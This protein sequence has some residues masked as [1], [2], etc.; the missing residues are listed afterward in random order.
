MRQLCFLF[1]LL[2]LISSSLIAQITWTGAGDGASWDD[3]ANW[4]NLT[5]PTIGDDVI[6]PTGSNVGTHQTVSIKSIDLQGNSFLTLNNHFT[7]TDT[8][9]LGPNSTLVWDFALLYTAPA[10][11]INNGTIQILENTVNLESGTLINNGVIKMTEVSSSLQI[12]TDAILTNTSNGN[13]DISGPV[14]EF[15]GLGTNCVFNNF[16]SINIDLSDS[17]DQFTFLN[18]DLKNNNGILNINKGILNLVNGNTDDIELTDGIYN[19]AA[20]AALDWDTELTLHGT[21]T[22]N[23]VGDLNWRSNTKVAPG[24]TAIFDFSGNETINWQSGQLVGGGTLINEDIINLLSMGA[25]NITDSSTLVNNSIIN[26][27]DMGDLQ[28][29]TNC[30][31]HNG[32][33]GIINLLTPNG[34]ISGLGASPRNFINDGLLTNQSGGKV[35]LLNIEA[36]NSGV[37]DAATGTLTFNSTLNHQVGGILKGNAAIELPLVPDFT[38]NG[39]IAPGD[40]IGKLTGIRDYTSTASTILDIE[41]NGLIQGVDYDLFSI[42]GDAVMDGEIMLTLGFAPML[43]DEFIIAT[44]TGTITQCSFPTTTTAEFNGIIYTF[45]IECRNDNEVVLTISD[46]S[47]NTEKLELESAFK[48]YPNP[49]NSVITIQNNGNVQ[50]KNATIFDVNGRWIDTFNLENMVGQKI[51]SISSYTPGI[52]LIRIN[53]SKSSIVKRIIKDDF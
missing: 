15:R 18:I 16:G 25:V 32:V 42:N 36:V 35:I 30:T 50:L 45:D 8:S 13:I 48:I 14:S 29:R 47:T 49:V 33:K 6:I 44:T 46:V 26:F 51:I 7:I 9:T 37:I 24:D 41:L 39:T 34:N 23:L 53:S 5:V 10:S 31:L 38:N 20:G 1:L 40:S 19:V 28:I 21:L 27:N 22:G 11:L 52:Y 2:F 3:A 4:D 12:R 17:M 43:N